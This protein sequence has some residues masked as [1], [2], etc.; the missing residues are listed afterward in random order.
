ML[1][2]FT[3]P[4]GQNDSG[5]HGIHVILDK[6]SLPSEKIIESRI[7]RQ[8]NMIDRKYIIYSLIN[9]FLVCVG[10]TIQGPTL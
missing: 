10:Q 4:R 6:V 8:E 5:K 7:Y 3:D 9:E 1:T 2:S